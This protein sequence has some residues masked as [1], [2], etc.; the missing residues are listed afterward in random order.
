M[1][2]RDPSGPPISLARALDRLSTSD[3]LPQLG[4]ALGFASHS[5]FSAAFR[6]ARGRCPAEFQR[7]QTLLTIAVTEPE[8][9]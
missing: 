3:D 9:F 8:S 2:L 5:H 4:L 6:Q 7:S 1:R